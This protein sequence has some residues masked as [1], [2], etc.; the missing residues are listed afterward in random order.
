MLWRK[1]LI[2][3]VK[4]KREVY[5]NPRTSP[6]VHLLHGRLFIQLSSW[7]CPCLPSGLCSHLTISTGPFPPTLCSPDLPPPYSDLYIFCFKNSIPSITFLF[8]CCFP[9]VQCKLPES[10]GRLGLWCRCGSSLPKF[11]LRLG[12]NVTVF[13]DGEVFGGIESW[14]LLLRKDLCRCHRKCWWPQE[15][16][17]AELVQL[18]W[19]SLLS[20]SPCDPLH[21]EALTAMFLEL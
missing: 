2:F 1:T 19:F 12:P 4:R 15:Q 9:S 21:H 18:P 7:P 10:G 14:G 8:Y 5:S 6:W 3:K 20:L 17:I 11:M 16:G 13:W